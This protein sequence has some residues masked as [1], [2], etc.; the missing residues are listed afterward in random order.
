M[1]NSSINN[2]SNIR[3]SLLCH[4][5]AV[6]SWPGLLPRFLESSTLIASSGEVAV[7]YYCRQAVH[8]VSKKGPRHY[9]L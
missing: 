7:V 6:S 3:V 1:I 4:K 5:V 9:R 2:N 8:C